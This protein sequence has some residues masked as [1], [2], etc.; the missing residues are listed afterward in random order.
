MRSVTGA[1]GLGGPM[2]VYVQVDFSNDKVQFTTAR[3]MC[4]S[5]VARIVETQPAGDH[6]SGDLGHETACLEGARPEAD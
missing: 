5:I 3:R 6:V 4:L 2:T 1:R